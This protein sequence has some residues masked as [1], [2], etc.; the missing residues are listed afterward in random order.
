MALKTFKIEYLC[1][2]NIDTQAEGLFICVYIYISSEKGQRQ[3]GS[4]VGSR[5][6]K[7]GNK[8]ASLGNV[9]YRQC[10]VVAIESILICL[11]R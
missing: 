5:R 6:G 9:L 2:E 8:P 7:T 1:R 3:H 11:T 10:D 4:K